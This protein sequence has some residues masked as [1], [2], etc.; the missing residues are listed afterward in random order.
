MVDFSQLNANQLEA[1]HWDEG[2]LL[3]LA[4]PGSG[5][6]RV[7]IY[8]IARIIEATAGAYFRVLGL[9][10]THAAAAEM[11]KRIDLLV[12]NARERILL[13]TFH[14]FC[15]AI[16]RQHGHHISLRP[17]FAILTQPEER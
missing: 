11:L 17:D 10:Y 13:T 9:T 15:A 5:K 1:V 4:G 8:R 16:L 14:A 7:L 6:T 12:P 2:R 3:V